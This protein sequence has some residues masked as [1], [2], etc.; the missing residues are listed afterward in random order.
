M[1]RLFPV[2]LHFVLMAAIW[3]VTLFVAPRPGSSGAIGLL[4]LAGSLWATVDFGRALW[5]FMRE[6]HEVDEE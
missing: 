3:T 4:L 2:L 1:K 6:R 5:R